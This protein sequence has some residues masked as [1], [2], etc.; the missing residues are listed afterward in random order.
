MTFC[1][2]TAGSGASFWTHGNGR[3]ET[4]GNGWTDRNGSRN[5]YLDVAKGYQK[6]DTS[7]Q[8]AGNSKDPDFRILFIRLFKT[9]SAI[10]CSLLE[11]T[12]LTSNIKIFE[13]DGMS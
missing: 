8:S 13:W 12:S 2:A 5:S 7:H 6:L 11:R 1:D 4:D 3:T 10:V 9:F